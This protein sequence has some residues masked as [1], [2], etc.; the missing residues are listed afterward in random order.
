MGRAAKCSPQEVTPLKPGFRLRNRVSWPTRNPA[1]KPEAGFHTLLSPLHGET[2]VTPTTLAAF[3]LLSGPAA[4]AVRNL[5]EPTAQARELVARLASTN[6]REREEAAHDLVR[7]GPDARQALA[8]GINH[9]DPEVAERCR[10]LLPA[11]MEF[12]LRALLEKH[13]ADPKLPLSDELPG[14]RRWKKIADDDIES[15]KLYLELAGH[16]RVLLSRLERE[17]G[18]LADAYRTFCMEVTQRV[19]NPPN[20]SVVSAISRQELLLFLFL[21]SDP[22]RK[23]SAAQQSDYTSAYNFLQPATLTSARTGSEAPSAP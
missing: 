23:K 5:G 22:V 6:F 10:R 21:G 2:A 4:D 1:S 19:R 8:D 12:H 18:K 13:L 11:A 16:H 7:L 3:A 17:P 20:G 9:S 15:R 14:A